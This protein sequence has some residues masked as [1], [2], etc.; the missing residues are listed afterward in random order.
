[1]DYQHARPPFITDLTRHWHESFSDRENHKVSA[2]LLMQIKQ[3]PESH[4]LLKDR[5]DVD[6]NWLYSILIAHWLC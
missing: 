4:T 1:M 3:L 2:D 5:K 6:F